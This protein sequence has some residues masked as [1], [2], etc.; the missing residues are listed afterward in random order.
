MPFQQSLLNS[1]CDEDPL[2]DFKS[3]SDTIKY[4]K[5]NCVIQ[6]GRLIANF[7]TWLRGTT[8]DTIA[9][10]EGEYERGNDEGP[11]VAM[12][13]GIEIKGQIQEMLKGSRL[14]GRGDGEGH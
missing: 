7:D 14:A 8:Q 11:T 2:T 12:V 10:I 13:M 1:E 9:N 5:N 3:G 6:F 4:Q